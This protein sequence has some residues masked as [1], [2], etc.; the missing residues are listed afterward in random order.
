ME[1]N[2]GEDIDVMI[3]D[4]SHEIYVDTILE[5]IEAAAKVR[6]TGIAGVR[7]LFGGGLQ[8]ATRGLLWT[9]HEVG[10]SFLAGEADLELGG[11]FGRRLDRWRA[12]GW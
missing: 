3:A 7:T 5:T 8:P 12:T 4:A 2:K 6:G 11:L 1:P 10:R 9:D